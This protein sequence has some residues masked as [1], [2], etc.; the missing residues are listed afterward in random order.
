MSVL[1]MVRHGQAS[2]GAA[3]YD[4]LSELGFKQ[5]ALLG[6]YWARRGLKFDAV[7]SGAQERQKQTLDEVKEAYIK[8]GLEF[9][10]STIMA[11]LNEYDAKGIIT[12]YFPALLQNDKRLQE[13]V[14]RSKNIGQNTKE[15]RRSFQEIFEIVVNTWIE[16]AIEVDGVESW[17]SFRNRVNA[18]VSKIVAEYSD[19][20]NV[21]VFTSGG[22][23]SA[24][25]ETTLATTPKTAIELSWVIKN[26]SISEFKFKKDKISLVGFNMT[27]HL[28]E[29]TLVT[30]R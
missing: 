19:G 30:Y 4:Q 11:G 17:S 23:I 5:S 29:D 26:A 15:G 3:N 27:P 16:G 12:K 21:A 10:Q 28:Y 14:G 6:E 20:K 1:F 7:F 22:P 8:A 24:L 13:I 25:M 9:P 2:F 18:D